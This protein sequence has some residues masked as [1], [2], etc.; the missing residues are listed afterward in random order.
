MEG[1]EKG[2]CRYELNPVPPLRIWYRHRAALGALSREKIEGGYFEHS[3]ALSLL[4]SPLLMILLSLSLSL[5][6]TRSSICNQKK[7]ASPTLKVTETC[8]QSCFGLPR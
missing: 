3:F 1:R 6:C 8:Y 4:L 5:S 7:G 2:A